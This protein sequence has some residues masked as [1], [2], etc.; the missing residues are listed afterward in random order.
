MSKSIAPTSINK[1]W[2]LQEIHTFY[3]WRLFLALESAEP[4]T[5]ITTEFL[6]NTI[7]GDRSSI[8]NAV[9]LF[10]EYGWLTKICRGVHKASGELKEYLAS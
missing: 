1:E 2:F 10:V 9:R 5:L 3:G 7:K 8:N 6:I 4:E